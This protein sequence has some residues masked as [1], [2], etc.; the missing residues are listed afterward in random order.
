MMAKLL[1]AC[2]KLIAIA[3]E[4]YS[5]MQREQNKTAPS[6]SSAEI[7]PRNNNYQK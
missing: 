4:L 5:P 1:V 7:I 2:S 3:F 6:Y